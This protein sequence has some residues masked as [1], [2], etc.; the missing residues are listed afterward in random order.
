M[1]SEQGEK[2]EAAD[3]LFY[4]IFVPSSKLFPIRVQ[5]EVFQT[6]WLRLGWVAVSITL[7]ID[8]PPSSDSISLP[9]EIEFRNLQEK[10]YRV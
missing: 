10:F 8:P 6:S 2:T 1:Y 4:R 3:K 7:Q 9:V 5:N